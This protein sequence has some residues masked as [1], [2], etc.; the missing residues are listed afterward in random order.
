M[1]QEPINVEKILSK[2]IVKFPEDLQQGMT[3]E[4]IRRNVKVAI[5]EIVE[6]VIDKCADEATTKIID[7]GIG[8]Y[9]EIDKDSILDI[10]NQIKYE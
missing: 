8:L 4:A 6:A 10:K 3:D 5:K 7:T 2:R 1:K 9:E